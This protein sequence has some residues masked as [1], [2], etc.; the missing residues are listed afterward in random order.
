MVKLTVKQ[1]AKAAAAGAVGLGL[2]IVFKPYE[3]LAIVG[4][5]VAI[6][7]LYAASKLLSSSYNYFKPQKAN[8]A[9]PSEDKTKLSNEQDLIKK[10]QELE[11]KIE[12]IN[13]SLVDAIRSSKNPTSLLTDYSNAI[14]LEKSW[15]RNF[16]ENGVNDTKILTAIT[17]SYTNIMK[18]IL[19]EDQMKAFGTKSMDM[20]LL[21][22]NCNE[23]REKINGPSSSFPKAVQ[24]ISCSSV[25]KVANQSSQQEE[26]AVDRLSPRPRINS[27]SNAHS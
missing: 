4:T 2:G 11:N 14:V 18:N 15:L 27:Q 3:T 9:K 7:T 24:D 26:T 19:P 16:K 10:E 25:N 8:D 23:L 21:A 13:H 6:G 5:P 22:I 20:L 12:D 1:K 17:T